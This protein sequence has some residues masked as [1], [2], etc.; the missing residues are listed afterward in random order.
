MGREYRGGIGFGSLM[1]GAGGGGGH[2]RESVSYVSRAL[3]RGNYEIGDVTEHCRTVLRPTW[4]DGRKWCYLRMEVWKFDLQFS[5]GS[6]RYDTLIF[7]IFVSCKAYQ[8]MYLT[9]FQL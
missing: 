7:Q 3:T 6:N 9:I 2:C 4:R 1:R 8:N 5:M